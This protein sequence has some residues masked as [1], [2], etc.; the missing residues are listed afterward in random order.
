MGGGPVN[1]KSN[2]DASYYDNHGFSSPRALSNESYFAPNHSH[3]ASPEARSFI[4]PNSGN[5]SYQQNPENVF[6]KS[7]LVKKPAKGKFYEQ[8]L[9][10]EDFDLPSDDSP[11]IRKT[12]EQNEDDEDS[13][14]SSD[15]SPTTIRRIYQERGPDHKKVL[16]GATIAVVFAIA[17][18]FFDKSNYCLKDKN[19]EQCPKIDLFSQ[20]TPVSRYFSF[21]TQVAA[22]GFALF[23]V[24]NLFQRKV[25]IEEIVVPGK[26]DQ[27]KYV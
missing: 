14:Y 3:E 22:G 12:F 19:L 4:Y 17:S 24:A 1:S 20:Y 11:V 25:T 9:E 18:V 2:C 7:S 13:D 16:I 5:P 15:K 23:S 26:V 21:L 10:E 27:R 6:S 8:N